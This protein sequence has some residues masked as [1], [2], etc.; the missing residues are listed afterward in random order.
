MNEDEHLNHELS[1]SVGAAGQ[2]RWRT[3][4]QKV[5]KTQEAVHKTPGH[6]LQRKEGKDVHHLPES[7]IA[8]SQI[9]LNLFGSASYQSR[10]G[11]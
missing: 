10:G 7:F 5:Q 3:I 4:T 11:L 2:N 8:E 1:R 6:N 9:K